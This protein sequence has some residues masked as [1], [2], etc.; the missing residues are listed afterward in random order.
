MRILF[1]SWW[2]PYPPN[3]G[4]RIRILNLLKQLAEHHSITLLAFSDDPQ[5]DAPAR[6]FSGASR[7]CLGA[8]GRCEVCSPPAHAP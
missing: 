1:I 4:S 6:G 7:S 8:G 5:R 3:N 2:F